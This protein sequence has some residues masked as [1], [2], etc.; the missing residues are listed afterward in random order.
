M[1]IQKELTLNQEV[2]M[3]RANLEK[4]KQRLQELLANVSVPEKIGLTRVPFSPRKTPSESLQKEI[5]K[6]QAYIN[7]KAKEWRDL[8]SQITG[9]LSTQLAETDKELARVLEAV[10]K[11]QEV[12]KLIADL[13]SK[14]E[15]FL[16][17]QG[18]LRGA[19]LSGF[20][21]AAQSYS[22][23]AADEIKRV[24]EIGFTVDTA[25]L[26]IQEAEIS[27]HKAITGTF[28]EDIEY[29]EIPILNVGDQ[30]QN[31]ITA[32]PDHGH[33]SIE[34]I[35]HS[36]ENLI[37]EDAAAY[38]A[39]LAE[40][41]VALNRLCSIKVDEFWQQYR[42]DIWCRVHDIEP[43]PKAESVQGQLLPTSSKAK[44][45]VGPPPVVKKKPQKDSDK[46]K[47]LT[48]VYFHRPSEKRSSLKLKVSR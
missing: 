31:L 40:V 45:R 26:K 4:K 35:N 15:A 3:L 33:A 18:H 42:E 24:G 23:M 1:L 28:A 32:S 38:E 11:P 37:T 14:T 7:E 12:Y 30:I 9:K 20:V 29:P 6:D 27:F 47:G 25:I 48:D 39:K 5:A 10:N 46:G 44:G 13:R 41:Q 19:L 17:S 21:P 43:A 36:C 2:S 34:K 8:K 22:K 16:E